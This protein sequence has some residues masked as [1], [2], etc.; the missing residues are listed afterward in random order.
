MTKEEVILSGAALTL[1]NIAEECPTM[2][3]RYASIIFRIDK[4]SEVRY[5]ELKVYFFIEGDMLFCRYDACSILP[6][7]QRELEGIEKIIIHPIIM[8]VEVQKKVE[9]GIPWLN[10]WLEMS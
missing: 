6:F 5:R 7:R 8:L 10:Y 4:G 2:G 1:E 9:E 3:T